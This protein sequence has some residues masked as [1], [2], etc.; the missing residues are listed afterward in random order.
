MGVKLGRLAEDMEMTSQNF[1]AALK[2]DNIKSQFL[3][4][5]ARALGRD[6]TMFYGEPATNINSNNTAG[7]DIKIDGKQERIALRVSELLQ[8]NGDLIRQNKML[9]EIINNLTKK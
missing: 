4:D 2:S 3:E 9:T 6:M 8:Q 7:R 1:S 5:I